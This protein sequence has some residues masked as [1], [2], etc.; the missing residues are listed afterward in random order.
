MLRFDVDQLLFIFPDLVVKKILT[1]FPEYILSIYVNNY[2]GL[3]KRINRIRKI[4]HLNDIF[5]S[6]DRLKNQTDDTSL[7]WD[8]NEITNLKESIKKWNQRKNIFATLT[9]KHD[10]ACLRCQDWKENYRDYWF[11]GQLM[12]YNCT[13]RDLIINIGLYC[14]E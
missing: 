8:Q 3:D 10:S 1:Y 11:N 7:I 6:I 9:F 4:T 2:D 14:Q 12:G 5:K 13:R